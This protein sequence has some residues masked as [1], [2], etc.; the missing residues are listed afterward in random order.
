MA[1]VPC[2]EPEPDAVT[3][4]ADPA[5]AETPAALR[6]ATADPLFREALGIAGGSLSAALDRL[7]AGIDPGPKRLRGMAMSVSRYALRMSGRPTPF[8][9]FAGVA[10]GRFGPNARVV[11]RGHAAKAVR[12]DAERL[13]ER[14]QAW[15]ALPE[16]RSR[17]DVVLND[18]S[19][20]R[21]GRLILP[22]PTRELSVRHSALVEHVCATVTHPVPYESV[23]DRTA[24]AFPDAPRDRLDAAV[25]QLL[26]YGFLISSITPHRLDDAL[27]DRIA[28]AIEELPEAAATFRATRIAVREYEKV[29]PGEGGDAWRRL[30]AL[31]DPDADTDHP[32][33]QVDLR[34]DAD[35][36][37]PTAVGDEAAA[38]ADAMWALSDA[39]V[40][41][42]HM[43]D[44]RDRFLDRYGTTRLVPLAELVDPH[45][46]LGFPSGYEAARAG[47]GPAPD[48]YRADRDRRVLTAE[49]VQE[50]L[51]GD[52][53][54]LRLTPDLIERL[55]A[56]MRPEGDVPAPPPNS[57]E[58]NLQLLADD[59]AALDEGRFRLI[60][61]AQAGSWLAG[62]MTGRFAELT[63]MTEEL[64]GLVA[65]AADPGTVPAQISFAPTGRRAL[66]MS[67]VPEL[68][69]YRIPVGIHADR[70]DPHCLDWREL[71]VGL[72]PIGLTLLMPDTGRRVLPVVPHMVALD[73]WAPEVVRLMVDIAFGRSRTW[74]GWD[75]AGLEV[76]PQLPR[77]THGR[78]VAAPRRWIPSRAMRA[79]VGEPREFDRALREW[80]D[81]YEV[82][83]RVQLVDGD[84]AHGL[85]LDSAWHRTL[86]RHEMRRSRIALLEDLTERGRGCGW[87]AGHRTELVVPLVRR[88]PT[89]TTRPDVPAVPARIPAPL[90]DRYHLPGEDWLFVKLYAI[91]GTHDELLRTHLPTLLDTVGGHIDRWFFI[92]YLDPRPHVRV[93]LHGD[94]ARLREVVLPE[95]AR[96]V[97]VMRERGAI[98]SMALDVYE[99]ETDRYAGPD[100][101]VAAERLFTLD[102][103]SALA[104][105]GMRARGGLAVPN[106]VLIAVNHALLLESL[107][108][109]DW[110]SWVVSA[111][112]KGPAQTVFRRHR[113]L[114]RELIRPGRT[115]A[116]VEQR[117]GVS[118]LADM[119]TRPA[120]GRAYGRTVLSDSGRR[121]ANARHEN[122]LLGL[123]HMQHNR[124]LGIDRASE[125]RGYAILRGIA[126][127]HL[128]RLAH[129]PRQWPTDVE[130]DRRDDG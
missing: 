23:L 98:R 115:A 83:D 63:D 85:D 31:L 45:R 57:L 111:F 103:R 56:T 91:P 58:L 32:P 22:G 93:R 12:L 26:R 24:E 15:L 33:A 82:P 127:D 79:S 119:W 118:A 37:L 78:V 96:R 43:R 28:G 102:S 101:L 117:L 8:G 5:D 3:S 42:L 29:P 16:V 99:P 39:W 10:T 124:L 86:L 55:A 48:D 94:P 88:R 21:D 13:H 9:L 100:A 53:R 18:L 122:A 20:V 69:P 120:E 44:Y 106:E 52:D 70:N 109:W 17:V 59:T 116:A 125:G 92:R 41:H 110:C 65:A 95:L 113:P 108:D 74:T 46:G 81:R 75:W 62:A 38:Y 123:L 49:L 35:I 50:A 6:R 121:P 51:L 89:R 87:A 7:D 104:Q 60:G 80:S 47:G 27:F 11:V 72:D 112:V 25:A 34:M 130:G 76:L 67:Q 4:S 90:P 19:R 14:V 84:R 40:T 129:P 97:R 77:V 2:A 61:S 36:V 114:V 66:N 107:G 54:E 128:G 68:L 64:A 71:L 1:S 30:T 73:H 126:S 105:L